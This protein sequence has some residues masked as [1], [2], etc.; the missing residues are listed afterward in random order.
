MEIIDYKKF[1]QNAF[2][3]YPPVAFAFA[4]VTQNNLINLIG[5]IVS[6]FSSAFYSSVLEHETQMALKKRTATLY[7]V[8]KS[9]M[10]HLP[11]VVGGLLS[12]LVYLW[13]LI[14]MYNFTNQTNGLI[15]FL[16]GAAGIIYSISLPL[17]NKDSKKL[18]KESYRKKLGM[19]KK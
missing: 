9:A 7:S 11:T 17:M 19:F 3:I 12:F 5:L 1:L 18:L 16:F 15:L 8:S 2:A 6:F 13:S 10:T 4:Y 14:T